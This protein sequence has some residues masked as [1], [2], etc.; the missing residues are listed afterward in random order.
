MSI[1]LSNPNAQPFGLLSNKANTP[2]ISQGITWTSVSS[3]VYINMFNNEHTRAKMSEQLGEN[4]FITM[5]VLKNRDDAIYY[6]QEILKA[7]SIRFSQQPRLRARL[8]ETRGSELVYDDSKILSLLNIIRNKNVIFDPLRGI[9]VDRKEVLSV[10]AGVE[11]EILENPYLDDNLKYVDLI[12]YAVINPQD[13]PYGDEIFIN[14]N[15]I[16]PILKF[17]LREKILANDI[18]KFKNHL[19]DVY[20]DYILETEYPNVERAD[21]RKAKFQQIVK[22][23]NVEKYENQLYNLYLKNKINHIVKSRLKFEPDKKLEE[24]NNEKNDIDSLLITPEKGDTPKVY[25]GP[26]DPF[27]PSFPEELTVDNKT[28]SSVVHYAYFKL[29]QRIDLDP[30]KLDINA[31]PLNKL[32]EMYDYEKNEWMKE[33]LKLNNET[34]TIAKFKQNEI[35]LHLL[36]ATDGSELIW[37]DKDDPFLGTGYNNSGENLSGRFLEYMRDQSSTLGIN[38]SNRMFSPNNIWYDSWLISKSR[39]YLNTLKLID[40]PTLTD[41]EVIYGIDSTPSQ[42]P[43]PSNREIQM[44]KIAGLNIEEIKLIFPLIVSSKESAFGGGSEKQVIEKWVMENERMA[45][46]P[47]LK[48]AKH[49]LKL[50]FDKIDSTRCS[51][52]PFGSPAGDPKGTLRVAEDIFIATILAEKPTDDLK[53]AK[54]QRIKYWS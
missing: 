38:I 49:N 52:R 39:D 12:Q 20:L 50:I 31:I 21:Y 33:K 45:R 9:E 30:R 47:N 15:N 35:L 11:K 36:R 2:F 37:N 10:I 29:T 42:T 8:Y 53:Q 34:A 28:F 23:K 51:P 7:L 19:L 14:V 40:R 22:E 54:W 3:Y 32:Q 5:Q 44:M 4:S 24:M 13:L 41:L 43:A 16:V 18:K 26:N 27:L 1:L 6:E 17:R 25:I 46:K 48:A